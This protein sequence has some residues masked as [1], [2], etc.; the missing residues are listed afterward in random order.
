[1]LGRTLKDVQVDSGDYLVSHG[2]YFTN[3]QTLTILSRKLALD[4]VA[5]NQALSAARLDELYAAYDA[6]QGL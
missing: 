5:A 3:P 4:W 2:G 1:M 6:T